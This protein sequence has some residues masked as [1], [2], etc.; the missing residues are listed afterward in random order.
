MNREAILTRNPL[1]GADENVYSLEK[2]T[3]PLPVT[4]RSFTQQWIGWIILPGM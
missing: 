3:E 2:L 4:I 1:G